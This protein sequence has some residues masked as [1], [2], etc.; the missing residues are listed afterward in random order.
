MPE[1]GVRFHVEVWGRR[2]W[3][4]ARHEVSGERV[5]GPLGILSGLAIP[6]QCISREPVSG[7]YSPF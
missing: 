4:H 3:P 5:W 1:A 7:W 6:E 2:L